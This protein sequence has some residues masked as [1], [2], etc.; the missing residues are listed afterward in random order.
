MTILIEYK[1]Q[2]AMIENLDERIEPSDVKFLVINTL[3]PRL[4]VE[5]D[6]K[7]KDFIVEIDHPEKDRSKFLVKQAK[8]AIGNLYW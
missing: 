5:K 4:A 3:L 8:D 2:T 1:D 6:A 7:K